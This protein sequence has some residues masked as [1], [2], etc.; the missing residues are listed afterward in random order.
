MTVEYLSSDNDY[1]PVDLYIIYPPRI[2]HGPRQVAQ[3]KAHFDGLYYNILST[4]Y[5]Y[6]LH[7]YLRFTLYIYT[8]YQIPI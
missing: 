8:V 6:N 7:I 2:T 3:V 1:R 4:T 5:T